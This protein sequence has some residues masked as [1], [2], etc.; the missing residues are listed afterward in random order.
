MSRQIFIDNNYLMASELQNIMDQTVI[1]VQDATERDAL[2]Q[3]VSVCYLGGYLYRRVGTSWVQMETD[4]VSKGG[5]TMTGA[6]IV[7]QAT[8]TWQ[9]TPKVYVDNQVATKAALSHTHDPYECGFRTWT[10]G[11]FS[12]AAGQTVDSPLWSKYAGELI[13]VTVQHPSTYLFAVANTTNAQGTQFQVSVRNSAVSTT[14]NNITIN[15][16]YVGP[17]TVSALGGE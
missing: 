14:M 15:V 9:V 16:L 13:F 4:R 6:L 8:Q 3:S 10:W 17:A 2:P 5:D 11:P 7:P 12:L 1:T